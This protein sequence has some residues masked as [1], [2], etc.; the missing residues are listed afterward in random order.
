ML[1]KKP[2]SPKQQK[3]SLRKK[4]ER[5]TKYN[6]KEKMKNNF[7]K[8]SDVIISLKYPNA[9]NLG[10]KYIIRERIF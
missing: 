6:Q 8:N 10:E 5:K 2:K 7:C 1:S 9:L 4:E 3:F